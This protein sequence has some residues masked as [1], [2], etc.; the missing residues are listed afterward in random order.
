MGGLVVYAATIR[1][2]ELLPLVMPESDNCMFESKTISNYDS[3]FV[4]TIP[5]PQFHQSGK[6]L[7]HI[8]Q[9]PPNKQ[10]CYFN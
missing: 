8:W 9:F 7:L 10:A 4:S 6:H 1:C 2:A 5:A 3:Q